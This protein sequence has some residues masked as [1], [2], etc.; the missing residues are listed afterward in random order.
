[1]PPCKEHGGNFK[2]S[3]GLR[4]YRHPENSLSMIIGLDQG[5]AERKS[6]ETGWWNQGGTETPT[7]RHL[8]AI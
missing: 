6:V 1:M 7:K 8:R 3:R 5:Q 4:S 2:S